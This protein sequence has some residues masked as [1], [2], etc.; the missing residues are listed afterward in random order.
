MDENALPLQDGMERAIAETEEVSIALNRYLGSIDLNME[1]LEIVQERL[2]LLADLRRKY[3]SNI[4]D[5][6]STLERLEEEYSTLN[7]SE[8]RLAEL[9]AE[10]TKVLGEMSTIGKKLS[11][12]RHKSAGNL[13]ESVTAELQDLNMTEARFKVDLHFRED[14][15]EWNAHGADTIQFLV[16]TNRGEP[17]R[18]LGKIAS[19]GELSR[20]MLAVRR[21]ISDKGGIGVYLF[22]EIDSGIGG[23]TAFQV[24]KKLGSVARY[25]QVI[26]IT[27]LPQVASFANHHWVVR[28]SVSGKRTLTE[29]VKLSDTERKNELA[30]MLGGPGLTK[31]SLENAAEM[32][33]SAQESTSA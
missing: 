13:S 3:G 27:H 20:L 14:I 26:C 21:V 8:E 22:D 25:N 18:P 17:E 6:L 9:Q 24:G 31:R 15:S 2:S 5:M 29:V 19:G 7:H 33:Q 4:N 11:S 32:L 1:R 23:H 30:R 28:K 16:Q 10:I 12:G